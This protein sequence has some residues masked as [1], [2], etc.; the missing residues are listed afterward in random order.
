MCAG[1]L[2]DLERIADE[3]LEMTDG[4]HSLGAGVVIGCPTAWARMAK[5]VALRERD[6]REEAEKLLTEGLR[7]AD[8]QDDPETAGWLCGIRSRTW[9]TGRKR[10]GGCHGPPQLRAD[11][12]LGDVFSRSV[13]RNASPM[14]TLSPANTRRRSRSKRTQPKRRGIVLLLE[15]LLVFA[16]GQVH[17]GEGV[18]GDTA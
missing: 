12:Q 6:H 4:D 10:G 8:E 3:M 13:A 17:V 15:C 16:G 9:P 11:R 1:D 2:D 14:C 5:A 7:I 18:E